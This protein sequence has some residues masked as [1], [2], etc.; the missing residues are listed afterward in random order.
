M[1]AARPERKTE[2]DSTSESTR[3]DVTISEESANSVRPRGKLHALLALLCVVAASSQAQAHRLGEGYIILNV[4]DHGISGRIELNLEDVDD[5]MKLDQNGDGVVNS[6][7]L[8]ASLDRLRQYVEPRVK[9]GTKEDWWS[10]KF[11]GHE[12]ASYPLGNYVKLPFVVEDTGTVPD[13]IEVEYRLL[14]DHDDNQKGLLVIEE[15]AR[16]DFKNANETVS[17]LFTAESPVQTVDLTVVPTSNVFLL[18]IK[19]GIWHIWIGLDHILF[20]VALLLS[21][22][23]NREQPWWEPVQSFRPAIWEVAKVVTLFTIAHSITLALASLRIVELPG[24]LIETIIAGSIVVAALDNIVPIFKGRIG[25]IVFGFGLFHGLGFASVLSHLTLSQASLATTLV[26]F[27]L[28][29]EIGQI[30]I[31][32]VVFP[33]LYALRKKTAYPNWVQRGLSSVLIVMGVVWMIERTLDVTI[34]GI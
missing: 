14:F 25:W 17:K 5:A 31:I 32:C 34:L 29:V 22:V 11:S 2:D 21:S 24:A 3:A 1:G 15:N 13:N 30:A 16:L 28:G 10:L 27:N 33:V 12:L 9:I 20:L 6:A 26:G 18:F 19:E 8:N 23:R 4:A 7:E